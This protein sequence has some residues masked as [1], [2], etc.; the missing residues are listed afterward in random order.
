MNNS[1]IRM[2][3]WPAGS[4]WWRV[5]DVIHGSFLVL[6]FLLSTTL[7]P[8]VFYHYWKLPSTLPN[9][10]YRILASADFITNVARPIMIAHLHLSPTYYPTPVLDFNFVSVV[11]TVVVRM[12]MTISFAAV[13][14]LA[15]TRAIKI[16]WPFF[17]IRKLFV[18]LWLIVL[19]VYEFTVLVLGMIIDKKYIRRVV[20]IGTVIPLKEVS[21]EGGNS[22]IQPTVLALLSIL[23]MYV[24][25]IIATLVSIWAIV[26]LAKTIKQSTVNKNTS[27]QESAVQRTAFERIKHKFK[28]CRAIF[29]INLTSLLTTIS[30]ISYLSKINR[31]RLPDG[32]ITFCHSTYV[33]NFLMPSLIAATNPLI[34]MKFN[35]ELRNR[36]MFWK[37]SSRS[38]SQQQT[39][40]Q[41]LPLNPLNK[42]CRR[43]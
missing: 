12:S 16:Q 33:V 23:P 30:T 11:S 5:S 26:A 14:L 2:Y 42:S 19:A 37:K 6:L 39:Q 15:L 28:G 7:N 8:I 36:A 10:L 27:D 17:H 4:Q 34:L 13:A 9:I 18:F 38:V 25:A 32:R 3:S 41:I 35:L 31:F 1:A 24:H 29:V 43:S 22:R 20:C 40:S 21:N